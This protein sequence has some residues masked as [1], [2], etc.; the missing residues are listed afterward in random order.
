MAAI[1]CITTAYILHIPTPNGGY[2]HI[3]D[4]MVY[5]AAAML[6]FPFGIIAS[7]IGGG[8]ADLLSAAT[9]YII[10]TVIIKSLNASCIYMSGK[11]DKLLTKKTAAASL[12]SGVFTVGGYYL[13]E[14]VISSSFAAPVVSIVPNIIQ[15]VSSAFIFI[16]F[17]Y[18]LD[19][20]KVTERLKLAR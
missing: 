2:I 14:V 4:S 10:P 18:A 16:V 20:A 7:A 5:L 15:A 17:A 3:G 19:K 11:H 12:L 13:A 1:I 8:M 6:P 9:I